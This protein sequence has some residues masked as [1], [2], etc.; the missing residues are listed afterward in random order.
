[1]FFLIEFVLTAIAVAV[2]FVLPNLGASWF[3]KVERL[4]GRLARRTLNSGGRTGGT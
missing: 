4:L 2:A 1:M 3:E